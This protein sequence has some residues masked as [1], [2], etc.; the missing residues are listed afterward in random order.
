MLML[1]L[2]Y[3]N[4]ICLKQ[5]MQ[6]FVP[7]LCL[8]FI[9]TTLYAEKSY[10]KCWKNAEGLTE[11]GN[12]IPREYYNQRVRYIDDKGVTRKV[13][14][15]AKT[16]EELDAQVEIDKLLA[17][18]EQQKRQSKN[19]DD[20]LL[21]TYLTIDDLLASLNSKLLIIESRGAV[22]DSTVE[23]KKREF[24]NLVRKAANM[25]RSGQTISDQLAIKLDKA[26]NSLRNIQAQISAQALETN[27]IKKIF[28]HDVERFILSKSNRIK[29]SLST[30]SQAKK[31]RAVRLS[32][33]NQAQCDIHWKKA[34][35]FIK[36][37]SSTKLRYTTDKVSVTDIPVKYRD[38]AMSLAILD[39]TSD[40]NKI[41]VF[42]IRCNREREGQEF[43]DSEDVTDL[44][45]EFKSVVYQ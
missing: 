15:K 45:K 39:N 14:E 21:K 36:E 4:T 32:C 8:L 20:V 26:R 13:K 11:C 42:Q 7:C 5:A 3:K 10:I 44:L 33:L 40:T 1:T 41:L 17:L 25:E 23:L 16:R 24:G 37:F 12:R 19:Y 2:L 6:L 18:E 30:P 31:L 38:I 29:H 9:S 35:E 28:A 43:C 22:L 34:N 27:K